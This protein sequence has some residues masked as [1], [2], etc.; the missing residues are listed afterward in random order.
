MIAFDALNYANR[1]DLGLPRLYLTD[2]EFWAGTYP[3]YDTS[4]GDEQ[5]TR[6]L[7]R[8]VSDSGQLLCLDIEHWPVDIRTASDAEVER[9]IDLISEIIDWIRDERPGVRLGLYGVLPIRDYWSPVTG[10]K[11]LPLWA[12]ANGRLRKAR[13]K[14]GRFIAEGLADRVDVLFPGGYVF[15]DDLAGFEK[16]LRANARE[17]RRY[18]KQLYLFYWLQFH[19]S[20]PTLGGQLVPPSFC[21]VMHRVA[22]EEADGCVLWSDEK[23]AW[24]DDIA[25]R[26]EI[27]KGMK[28]YRNLILSEANYGGL[29]IAYWPLNEVN[30]GILDEM[31]AARGTGYAGTYGGTVTLGDSGDA[32]SGVGRY[33]TVGAAFSGGTIT[34]L[35][36][37]TTNWTIEGWYRRSGVGGTFGSAIYSRW[38]A[39]GSGR[40]VYLYR[41]ES[42]GKLQIDV[43]NIKAI[44]TG[45]TV[46][47]SGVWHHVAFTRSGNTWTI[48]L[49]GAADGGATDATA[50]ESNTTA[51]LGSSLNSANWLNGSLA[52]VAIYDYALSADRINAHYLAGVNGVNRM[53]AA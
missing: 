32:P 15:Y 4:R 12:T 40:Q 39:A 29:P 35:P 51:N 5:R 45:N 14:R 27:A 19:N 2:R 48:Y 22:E 8:R 50:Q 41:R 21:E 37:L 53:V 13:D 18:G 23:T 46:V 47:S 10:G 42:D 28:T 11:W 49:D 6:E 16:D 24:S 9:S 17:G 20:N 38:G 30:G 33:M 44:K 43:P 34:G 52:H 1:P 25:Q 26:V 3:N 31:T 36:N 7:A